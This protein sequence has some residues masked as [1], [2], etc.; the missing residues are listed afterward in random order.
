MIRTAKEFYTRLFSDIRRAEKSV[1][2]QMYIIDE[3]NAGLEFAALMIEK[4]KNG[5]LTE[6]VYDSV[7]CFNTPS[8]YFDRMKSA[9]VRVMEYNPVNPGKMPG[10]FSFRALMRRNHRKLAVI[11][12]NVYYLGGMNI[13][14]RF[15]E[16]EDIMI[17]GEGDLAKVFSRTFDQ[18][19]KRRKKKPLPNFHELEKKDLQVCDSRP[20][21]QN[22]PV[23]KMHINAIKKAK[24]RIW[25]AQAYFIPRRR[26]VKALIHAAERG[27]DVRIMAPD[28]SDVMVADLAA[29]IPLRR[30]MT[31]GVKVMRYT[32][33]ML[34]SKFTVIDDNWMTTGTANLDSMSFY[35]NLEMNLVIRDKD[36]VAQFSRIF[37]DYQTKSRLVDDLEP[38][39]RSWA[40]RFAG[41][42][43]YHYSWIL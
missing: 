12:N 33:E 7:G 26:I 6:L 13:G 24:E 11:D 5:L 29:W 16:W 8:V 1:Q 14:E 20:T 19:A 35:W 18:L 15:L 23:K 10:P 34:H 28:H 30:L 42:V 32:G 27:V 9:G 38:G 2:V 4:A 37:E 21:F 36:T 25:I 3:D 22:Y 39:N 41:A 17:R 43:L 31:H 40:V